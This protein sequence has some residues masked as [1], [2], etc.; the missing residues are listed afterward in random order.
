[1][2]GKLFGSGK[3]QAAAAVLPVIRN[4]TVGRTVVLDPL[5]WRRH[6]AELKFEIDRDTLE[7]SAQGLIQLEDGAWVHRFYT[8]DH[9]MLQ[10]VSDDRDGRLANDFTL[11]IPWKS[12]YPGSS[13]EKRV[14]AEKLRG[15]YFE[16]EG[17][18]IYRRLWFGDEAPDQ[19]PVSFWEE[20]FDDRTASAPYARIFQTGMLFARDLP[21]E[22]R[23]LLLAITVEP[24]AGDTTHDIMIGL[25]VGV[26]E[27]S[28]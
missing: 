20:V 6:G 16:D 9:L 13:Q 24:E 28:A 1:M 15:P 2:F 18:P 11:F 12:G 23:E 22:G 7:V 21:G 19:A 5:I 3:A 10:I 25:P 17:L 26:G 27:F 4:I 14:W 8:D